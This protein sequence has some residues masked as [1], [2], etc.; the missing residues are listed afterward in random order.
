MIT[1]VGTTACCRSYDLRK[2][3]YRAGL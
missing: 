2:I 1:A 3:S